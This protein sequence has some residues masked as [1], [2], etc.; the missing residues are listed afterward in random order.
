MS[1][2]K[3]LDAGESNSSVCRCAC[4]CCCCD[5]TD[6]MINTGERKGWH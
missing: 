1:L 2:V 4:V 6:E 5:G 3:N